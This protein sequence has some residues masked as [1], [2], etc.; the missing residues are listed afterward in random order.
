MQEREKGTRRG[1]ANQLVILCM[2]ADPEPDDA[3]SRINSHRSILDSDS[4][5]PEPTHLLKM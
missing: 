3:I 5:R 1:L 2:S 4:G